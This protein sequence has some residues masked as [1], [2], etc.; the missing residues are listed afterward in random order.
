MDSQSD[1]ELRDLGDSWSK[2]KVW[3][4]IVIGGAQVGR[5]LEVGSNLLLQA[6]LQTMRLST[7]IE[8]SPVRSSNL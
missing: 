7:G 1:A 2:P 3:S 8:A 5:D 4:F 6:G